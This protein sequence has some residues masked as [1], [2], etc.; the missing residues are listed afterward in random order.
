MERTGKGKQIGLE[1]TGI[2]ILNAAG[3]NHECNNPQQYRR[4]LRPLASA[5]AP[6]GVATAVVWIVK[7]TV[8]GVLLYTAF[9]LA[10]L[11]VYLLF[12]ARGFG[13]GSDYFSTPSKELRHGPAGFGWYSSGGHRLDPHDPNGPY[14]D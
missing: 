14:G 13:K 11:L 8:L 1:Q 5:G 7:L 12:V 4:A 2:T 3:D 6:S 10:L 9:W